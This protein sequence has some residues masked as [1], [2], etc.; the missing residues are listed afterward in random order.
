MIEHV[1]YEAGLAMLRECFRVLKPG[2]VIRLSTPDLAFLVNLYRGPED[3]NNAQYIRHSTDTYIR[4]APGYLPGF[5]INNFVRDWG[6]QFIYD[7]KTLRL[8][9]AMAGFKDVRHCSVGE[10]ANEELNDLE[11]TSRMPLGFLSLESLIL[12]GTKP[13]GDG[14]AM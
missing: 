1:P 8:S 2:G 10:S 6:H 12:E 3:E 14:A 7:Q 11:N 13:L 9:F 4:A 5:V